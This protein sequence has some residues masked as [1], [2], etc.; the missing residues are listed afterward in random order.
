M[1]VTTNRFQIRTTF[2]YEL[3]MESTA[4]LRI[5]ALVL[6]IA[7]C[8]SSGL[9]AGPTYGGYA[10][11]SI[12]IRLGWSG[13]PNGFSF[14][15]VVAPNHAFEFVF[16]YNGKVGRTVDIPWIRKG[17]TFVSA[18][19]APFFQLG[20]EY[21]SALILLDVG[22]RMRYHHYRRLNVK[23]EGWKITPEVFAGVG[24]QVEFT[25]SVE[26]FADLHVNLYNRADNQY[27]FGVE[28]GLGIRFVLN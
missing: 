10:K 26:V 8:M 24:M 27:V 19:Y 28:S 2:L 15:N 5:A 16:G 3:V 6:L 25:N 21:F 22:A 7:G 12:G 17:N 11:K 20:D 13:A 9:M 4:R 18:S 23:R 1:R 14:R